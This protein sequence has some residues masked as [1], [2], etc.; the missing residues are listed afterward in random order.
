MERRNKPLGSSKNL[1]FPSG[2]IGETVCV[3]AKELNF[4]IQSAKKIIKI[5]NQTWK[6]KNAEKQSV[7]KNSLLCLSILNAFGFFT[8]CLLFIH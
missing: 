7:L 3:C 2:S 1:R 8:L 6:P 4:F 5:Q